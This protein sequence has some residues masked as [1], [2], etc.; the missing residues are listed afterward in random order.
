MKR[1]YALI[2]AAAALLCVPIVTLYASLQCKQSVS[3]ICHVGY[4][5]E[6]QIVSPTLSY[7]YHLTTGF[8]TTCLS[9][10]TGGWE[11]YTVEDTCHWTQTTMIYKGEAGD[12]GCVYLWVIEEPVPA[13]GPATF[14]V[15]ESSGCG[16]P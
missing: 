6:C 11:C 16:A 1:I 15:I 13:T 8:G 7:R 9:T 12:G 4:V 5:S 3:N 14:A 10:S 2:V